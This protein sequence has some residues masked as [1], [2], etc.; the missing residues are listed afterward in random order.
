MLQSVL[1]PKKCDAESFGQGKR[2]D[3]QLELY[4]ILNYV[5]DT[6]RFLSVG[7]VSR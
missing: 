1:H 6:F 3:T 4:R 5:L 7:E 2:R